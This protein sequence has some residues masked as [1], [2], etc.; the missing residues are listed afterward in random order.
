MVRELASLAF[1]LY[2]QPLGNLRRCEAIFKVQCEVV[3][4]SIVSLRD[5]RVCMLRT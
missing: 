3:V 1:V 5:L 4:G 2:A